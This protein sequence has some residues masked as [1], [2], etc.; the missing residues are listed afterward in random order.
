MTHT[1]EDGTRLFGDEHV[2]RYRET[3]GAV[4]HIWK[5]GSTILL[6]TTNGRKTGRPGTVPLIYAED[7][8]RY[9]IVASKG[10][11][12]EHPGWYR[13]LA[14]DPNVEVQVL[15]EVFPA[16][17]RTAEGEERERLWRLANEIW[18]HYD[19]YAARTSRRIPVV[20]LERAA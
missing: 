5:E 15:D 2:R 13:N 9:V 12:P 7:G 3:D 14:K 20:V 18:P 4:G 1:R 11:A 6:L 17:A 8:D 16:H 19:E 10:G